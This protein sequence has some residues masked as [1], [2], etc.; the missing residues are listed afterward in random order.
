MIR[1]ILASVAAVS[2]A[3][4]PVAAQAA[5]ARSATPIGESEGIAGDNAIGW[6]ALAVLVV[7]MAVILIDDLSDD[8]DDIDVPVSP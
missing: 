2:L 5:P 7:A 8:D 4:A 1:S 3:A 6:A